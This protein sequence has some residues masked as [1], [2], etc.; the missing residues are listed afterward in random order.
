MVMIKDKDGV[1][2]YSLSTEAYKFCMRIRE[3]IQKEDQQ[4]LGI[5]FGKVGCGKSVLAQH[6]GYAIDPTLDITK[7]CFTKEEFID[8]VINSKHQVIVADE[9]ISMFFSRASMT[10]EGR[11]MSEIM[12]QIRQKNLCVLICV[13]DVMSMDWLVLN[14]T[15]FVLYVW[16]SRKK[17]G[18]KLVTTKGNAALFPE[19]P[20]DPY[21]T[22]I[23]R[24]LQAKKRSFH[25]K[26]R[27]PTEFCQFPGNPIGET[28]KPAWYPVGESAYKKK[29]EA[30]LDKYKDPIKKVSL[31]NTDAKLLKQQYNI[32]MSDAPE[33]TKAQIA[34]VSPRTIRLWKKLP[35]KY[36]E[37]FVK[38][39]NLGDTEDII[40]NIG[41]A[42]QHDNSNIPK[43][44]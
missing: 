8:A 1:E 44:K 16:E 24:Y 36:P 18:K 15:N 34:G 38:R 42:A 10:K 3:K 11:L 25:K 6:L 31:G 9:G 5:V 30:I 39:G 41:D 4:V 28:Y 20:S 43:N 35:L 12:A 23:I 29:K 14:A 27:R 22:K 33:K 2:R 7:V 32:A 26:M 19:L 13:P 40:N 17:I 21:K 37:L